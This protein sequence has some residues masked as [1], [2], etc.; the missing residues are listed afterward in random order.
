M[1]VVQAQFNGPALGTKV[2]GRANIPQNRQTIVISNHT[3]HLDMGLVKYALGDY[4]RQLTALAAKDYF[5]EGNR[6]K[7]T[8]FTHF[9]NVEPLDRKGGFRT[10]MREARAVI[11]QGKVVLIFPEGTRQTDG[12]LGEFKPLVGKLSL[13]SGVDILPLYIDGAHKAMPKG[14]MLPTRRGVKVRIGLPLPV[15][16]LRRL[17]VG[18]KASDAARRA[19]ELVRMAV[20]ALGRGELLDISVL[21]PQDLTPTLK[22]SP[23]QVVERIMAGLPPRFQRDAFSEARTWYFT[24]GGSDG[25]RYTLQVSADGAQVHKGKPANGAD[26]VVKTSVE[27]FRKICE[28][29]YAPD[30][31]E[32]ISGAIKVSEIPLLIEFSQ[33]FNLSEARA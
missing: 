33:L 7:V 10:S 6:L 8:W 27:M 9:T 19:T 31:S 18:M 21:Q 20:E 28:E 29:A 25:P 30:P 2:Y 24:L 26:C 23:E 22:L 5:F 32:F 4:G 11:D 16:H 15:E 12:T 3:S 1:R 13:D 17:T 14:R